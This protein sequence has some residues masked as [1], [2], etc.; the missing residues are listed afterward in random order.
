MSGI[1]GGRSHSSASLLLGIRAVTSS[2]TGFGGHFL[3]K[4]L[5][6][7]VTLAALR[8]ARI[9]YRRTHDTGP[10][11]GPVGGQDD[12]EAQTTI[13]ISSLS[14]AGIGW[15]TSGDALL[16]STAADMARRRRETGHDELTHE[17]AQVL[18]GEAA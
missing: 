5:R 1:P 9:T 12:L 11:H 13:V 6:Y 8:Q 17:R 15:H 18:V 16:A 14:Y 10:E 2:T 4:A 7:S 3:T